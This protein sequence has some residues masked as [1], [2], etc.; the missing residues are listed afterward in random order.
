M[1]YMQVN[2]HNGALLPLKN[3]KNGRILNLA[4]N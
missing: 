3:L 1:T 2:T 4:V